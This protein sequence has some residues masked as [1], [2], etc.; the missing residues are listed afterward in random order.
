[1]SE[2]RPPLHQPPNADDLRRAPPA[3]AACAH[4]RGLLRDFADEDLAAPERTLVEEHV[5]VCFACSVELSRAEHEVLRLRRGFA[6]LAAGSTIG[7]S[8][9]PD[10]ARRIVDRIVDETPA[11]G[12]SAAGG[13]AANGVGADGGGWPGA[14]NSGAP[15]NGSERLP[16]AGF[17]ATRRAGSAPHRPAFVLVAAALLLACFG[18]LAM[19]STGLDREPDASARL[20]V[21]RAKGAFGTGGRLAIG[22]GLGEAQWLQV[23]AGGS[24]QFDWHDLSSGSQPAATLEMTGRGRMRLQRG[25]PLLMDG[26]LSIET[27]RAVTIP[28]ADGSTIELGIGDYVIAADASLASDDYLDPLR[29]PMLSAPA[30]LQ[31]RIEV[32]RGDPARIVGTEVG[33][34]LVAAGSVGIYGSSAAGVSVHASGTQV[35]AV[36]GSRQGPPSFAPASTT[37]TLAASVHLRSGL[38]SVGTK[39]AALFATNGSTTTKFGI[40]NAYGSVVLTSDTP[41]E[42]DF[43]ILHT[44]PQQM[45]YGV[46]APDAFP[47]LRDG[48]QV[49]AE[50]SL[51]LDLAEPL[52][53][54]V[55]DDNGLPRLGVRVL[56]CIVDELFGNVFAIDS[57]DTATDEQG[58]FLIRRLPATLP[59]Y[60]HLALVMVHPE[61]EPTV[62]PVPV[63]SGANA[64]LPMAPVVMHDLA[65]VQLHFL[66]WNA[67]VTLW[68]EVPNLAAGVAVVQREFHSNPIGQKLDARVG[69]GKLW[70]LSGG[71]GNPLVRQMIEMGSGQTRQYAPA[72][73]PGQ[74]QSRFFRPMQNLAGTDLFLGVSFR[75]EQIA[76]PSAANA[77]VFTMVAL[78]TL[79]RPVANAQVFAV[80]PTGPRDRAVGR[81]LGLTSAQG[82][83]S[84]E[85]VQ[86]EGD[87]VVLGPDGST[88]LV[89]N[90]QASAPRL[91]AQLAPRGRV[92]LAPALRPDA[93][94][95]SVV[96]L[97]FELRFPSTPGLEV[98]S[99]RF[100]SEATGWEFTGLMP[101]TYAVNVNGNDRLID[102]P[103]DGWVT[104]Q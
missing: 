99:V 38:P 30:D 3:N 9:P 102:V 26:S 92:L 87:L 13:G 43:A 37:T 83:I 53:G 28:V 32:L 41:C 66:P 78:D 96:T 88:A 60:Q 100:A 4:V 50:Q 51:V 89:H 47:L 5:H 68:E 23:G 97:R 76:L 93:I 21:M 95:S 75:H 39:I 71:P 45:E 54:S 15:A 56:P 14:L 103:E 20:V 52:Q 46:I 31:I 65:L 86:F 8:V 98:S 59:Y 104:L 85:P 40:T 77:S 24:A 22:D 7:A 70:L 16:A 58:R 67:P 2:P 57:G 79:N 74:Q 17:D 18:A 6:G 91:D 48:V 82:V 84:L 19:W 33:P 101:G 29:D 49:R 11:Y 72:P 44:V 81:F 61:L 63:R 69:P 10:F 35:A 12:G 55:L 27:N 73:L 94:S 25:A 90:P 42:S 64:L 34:T 1:M 80:A 62:V 36:D